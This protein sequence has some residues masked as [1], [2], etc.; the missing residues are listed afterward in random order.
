MPS[1][2]SAVRTVG[3]HKV[4]CGHLFPFGVSHVP[5]GVNFS[6]FSA[7]A[8]GC[9]LVLF[10]PDK[11]K[12][13]A[14]IPFPDDFRLGHVWAMVVHDIDY[15]DLEY[16][17][18][19]HG[20]WSP[21]EGH[22]F[23]DSKILLD[24]HAREIVGREDWMQPPPASRKP[25]F[26]SRV[27]GGKGVM[28]P[29]TVRRLANSELVI[30]EM[31]LR[32]FTRH[33]SSGV[34]N[35]GTYAGLAEKI[36]SL[37]DLG[38]NCVELMPVFEFDETE[39]LR[40]NP[41]D[42][43]TLCNYWGY[44]TVGFFAPKASYAAGAAQ[45]LQ[46]EEMKQMVRSLHG[47]GI[48]VMLDVVFNH[49]AEG[50]AEG[51]VFSFRGIDNKTWY[52]LDGAGNFANYSGCGN[53]MNCNYPAVREFVISCLRYWASEYH[54]DGFRF[55]LA[56]ILGRDTQGAP[57]ANP[58]LLEFLAHDPALADCKLVAEAW[59]AGGLYQVGN[60]PNYGRWMEW[61]GK[62]RD[63]MRRFL[64]GDQGMV[65][66]VVQR[67][68]GS[69]DLYAAAGRKPTASVNF[70]TCHDGFTLRDLFSYNGKHNLENGESNRDGSDDNQ[71]WNCG[72]EGE[73]EDP[74]IRALR[75]RQCK[76]AMTLLMVSQGVPMLNM[77]DEFGRTQRGNNNAYCHDADWNWLN[78]DT[79]AEG[80]EIHRYTKSIIA[81]RKANP[82]LRQPEFLSERD[83]VGSGYPD[84]SWHGVLP[85]HPDWSASSRSVAFMLCGRHSK[86]IG[87][88][89]HFIYV[90]C[91]M[92]YQ[93]LNFGLPVLPKSM[94]WH[95]FADTSL[96]AP[97]DICDIG[98]ETLLPV[99]KS[100]TAAEW[101]IA[102]LIGK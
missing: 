22:Y 43:E 31:H 89:P 56:S 79:D 28:E 86:S 50:G 19:M 91:N 39:N 94:K 76:N 47:A 83:Q 70:I 102:I 72:A 20:P 46:V 16:G 68:L 45:K 85:W 63:C 38:V 30:Y 84:I 3:G 53:T 75:V 21:K 99:Q 4:S 58:P 80:R 57:L 6:I 62:Y 35:P 26:R 81:F 49:T 37:A 71:S 59:D 10:Q 1:S 67:I 77:G 8:T 18:R 65:G 90:V 42:G 11:E 66:E 40:T 55:D 15:N 92:Y 41:T 52:I 14:E 61:N 82:V 32:G 101:S 12:P 69:P 97:A 98:G 2:K 36:Q 25:V 5:A 64:K 44:S 95:R 17:F 78:W 7:H 96:P 23:D 48:E 13:V 73:T 100:Y 54:I 51:P 24:P 27:P 33:P 88:L 93:P 34:K 29:N 87:G 60:F 74:A 9:T